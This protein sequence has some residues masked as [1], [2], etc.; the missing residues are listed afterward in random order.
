MSVDGAI[1]VFH[2]SISPNSNCRILDDALH[3]TAIKAFMFIRTH[4]VLIIRIVIIVIKPVRREQYKPS[5]L[6]D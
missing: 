1:S 2:T 6:S 5:R 4:V 3:A